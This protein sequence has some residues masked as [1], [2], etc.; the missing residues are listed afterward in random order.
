MT[1]DRWE[2]IFTLFD[3]TLARPGKACGVSL[4]PVWRGCA[5]A[6]GS[7]GAAGGT[8]RLRGL[9]F[10][11]SVSVSR[12]ERQ[13]IGTRPPS[14]T[15]G[16]RLGVFDIEDIVGAGGMGEVYKARDTRLNRHVAIKVLSPDGATDPLAGRASR[17]K[18]APSRA[19]R[20][21]ASVR[22]TRWATRTGRLPRHGVSRR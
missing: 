3:A 8:R 9:P 16:M 10:W 12:D 14:L 6:P 17:T 20:I 2:R 1:S 18:P 21:R 19:S 15:R 22:C 5:P 13:P 7:G 11:P 4:G